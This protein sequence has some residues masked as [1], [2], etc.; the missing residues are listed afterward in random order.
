MK[1]PYFL[2]SLLTL[3]TVLILSAC[4]PRAEVSAPVI[5]VETTPEA[6]AN[7]DAEFT[8]KT[9]AESG[10]LAYVGVGGEIDGIINPD[11][12]I[13]PGDIVHIN[14]VNGDGMPHDFY[15]PDLDIKTDYV[16]KI[17]DKV[18]IVFEVGDLQPGTYSYY[19]TVP[20]HR[21]AGQEGKLI[22]DETSE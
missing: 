8:L 12:I 11:L 18:E 22:V 16:V 17:D 3:A 21:Q 6:S 14:L 9:V 15:Q 19:C 13:K 2:V 10:K 4:S 20:G 7:F 1:Y 5:P